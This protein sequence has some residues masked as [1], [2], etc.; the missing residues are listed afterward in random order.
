MNGKELALFI[1]RRLIARAD[2]QAIQSSTGGYRPLKQPFTLSVIYDHIVGKVS[3][4]HYQLNDDDRCKFFAFDLDFRDGEFEMWASGT[5]DL[6]T[7]S[8]TQSILDLEHP[9]RSTAVAHMRSLGEALASRALALHKE[10]DKVVISFSGNKGLH[11]YCLFEGLIGADIAR[12]LAQDV[13]LDFNRQYAR[14]G[15]PHRYELVK[16]QNFWRLMNSP[17]E[18]LEIET[19]P[20]QS[21]KGEFGNL[22][23]LPYGVHAKSGQQGFFVDTTAPIHELQPMTELP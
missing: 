17:Y 9:M 10:V 3:R 23:R 6:E 5:S 7:F 18:A 16:G 19:F 1:A 22:L 20:K 4:G 12:T 14:L 21:T 2:V 8:P 13:L 15:A 11:V